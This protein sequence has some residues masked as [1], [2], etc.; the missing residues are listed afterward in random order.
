MLRLVERLSKL[1]LVVWVASALAFESRLLS[2]GWPHLPLLMA[3][4][5]VGAVVATTLWDRD[6]YGPSAFRMIQAYPWT[7]VGVGMFHSLASSFEGHLRLPPDNAQHSLRHQVAKLGLL[8]SAPWLLWFVFVAAFVLTVPRGELPG[9]LT[10]RGMLIGF[11][12]ISLVS[13]P[14][15]NPAV[16]VT[17]WTADAGRRCALFLRYRAAGRAGLQAGGWSRRLG[18]RRGRREAD[19]GDGDVGAPAIRRADGPPGDR[20][21]TH[22]P[23]RPA[24]I[25]VAVLRNACGSGGDTSPAARRCGRPGGRVAVPP[26][27]RH[28]TIPAAMGTARV[29][30]IVAR[31]FR[32]L[33]AREQAQS[34]RQDSSGAMS[35]R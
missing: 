9:T 17:F 1:L 11:G 12:V 15:Q 13:M 26:D 29:A 34:A 31:C 6:G 4:S 33:T 3:A 16:V 14:G 18:D 28:P 19:A 8:G 30:S 24:V 10:L 7:G 27:G 20:R 25:I 22:D 21:R 32:R 5:L 2:G 23:E 35:S